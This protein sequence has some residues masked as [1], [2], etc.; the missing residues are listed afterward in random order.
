[1]IRKTALA[2][3]FLAAVIA[4]PPT[5]AAGARPLKLKATPQADGANVPVSAKID[6]PPELKKLPGEKISVILRQAGG[7]SVAGQVV[8]T[9][10][11]AELWWILPKA[12]ANKP[13][14]WT[15]ELVAVKCK[16]AEMF[17]LRDEAGKH[18]DVLFAGKAVTRYMYARDTSTKQR[19]HETYKVYNHVF[20][21]AGKEVITKGPG[22]LYTHHRGIFIGWSKTGFDGKRYDTWHMKTTTQVHQKF[23]HQTAGPVFA[24]YRALVHWNITGPKT[25]LSEQ[26]EI[27]V[28]R[29]A[30]GTIMLMDFRTLLTAPAGEVMLD[31]DPEHAGCQFRPHNDLATAGKKKGPGAKG[32][33]KYLFHREGVDPRKDRD[34]PWVAMSYA[35][36]GKDYNVQHMSHPGIPRGNTYSAYRPYGRFGAYFKKKIPEGKTLELRYRYR[37]GAGAMPTR[38][39]AAA[40]YAAFASPPRVQTVK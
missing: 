1:M 24:R 15:V 32:G 3:A 16:M 31:G 28:F 36:G 35:L 21:E 27:T 14:T 7:K 30:A 39:E 37:V 11:G 8:H 33:A 18:L 5:P 29:Q 9:D 23:L 10:E 38:D 40:R 13:T 26:R 4:Q 20:D 34:L 12:E 22:G 19:A 2:V 25:I 17:R 6:L